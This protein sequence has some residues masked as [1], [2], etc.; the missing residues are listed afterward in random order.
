MKKA[1]LLLTLLAVGCMGMAQGYVILTDSTRIDGE[2]LRNYP[3]SLLV[4]TTDGYA[5]VTKQRIAGLFYQSNTGN[6]FYDLEKLSNVLP[7]QAT[8][9]P[10]HL[11]AKGSNQLL[12]GL[13]VGLTTSMASTLLAAGVLNGDEVD[14]TTLNRS[15]NLALGIAVGGTAISLGYTIG[16]FS[17]LGRAGKMM[18]AKVY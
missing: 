17:N 13:A 8:E 6:A 5:L 3:S 1:T 16:G 12:I 14:L 4:T 10:G 11:I 7:I 2:I 18:D 9:T 15:N